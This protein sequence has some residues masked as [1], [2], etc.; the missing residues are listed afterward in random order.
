MT[1]E[2]LGQVDAY[3]ESLMPS[4]QAQV[5]AGVADAAGFSGELTDGDQAAAAIIGDGSNRFVLVCVPVSDLAAAEAA[6]RYAAG[7]PT[8]V[9][10][11]VDLGMDLHM[12][13]LP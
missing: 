8:R 9:T 1:G 11:T 7:E 13:I 3:I 4:P 10:V 12:E 5:L 6:R 2:L